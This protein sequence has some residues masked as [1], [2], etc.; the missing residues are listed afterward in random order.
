MSDG[1]SRTPF[2][3]PSSRSWAIVATGRSLK[4]R[5]STTAW[6]ASS[7]VAVSEQSLLSVGRRDWATWPRYEAAELGF[8]EYWYPV[9]W[10]RDVGTKP[11]GVT[12][13]GEPILLMREHGKLYAL[14]DRCPHRGVPMS[15]GRQEFPGTL[16]CCYHGWTFD[17]KD[18]R[19]VAAITDGPESPICGKVAI[20]TYPVEERIGL[21]WVFIG[22][23]VPPPVD[24][25]IPDELLAAEFKDPPTT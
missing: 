25:E 4:T 11:K 24:T 22:D 21:V 10:S 14:H 3:A 13:L 2:L 19:L 7:C 18:G 1:S 6:S 20:K 8:R 23:G 5:R 12:V 15:L 17:L 9:L 16:S